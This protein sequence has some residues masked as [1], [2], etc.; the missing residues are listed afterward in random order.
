MFD[1]MQDWEEMQDNYESCIESHKVI[2]QESKMVK[3][4]DDWYPNFPNNEIEV[5][6]VLY[7]DYAL[8]RAY[9]ADDTYVEMICEYQTEIAYNTW[10]EF[11]YDKIPDVVNKQWFLEHGFLWG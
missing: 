7:K 6:L 8:F 11:I 9:G 5:V 1:W 2:K 4:N 3:V 10:K